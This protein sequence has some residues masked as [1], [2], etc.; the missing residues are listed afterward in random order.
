[1]G[2][3]LVGQGSML[4]T[5]F[6]LVA[7][8]NPLAG[9]LTTAIAINALML[10]LI[11]WGGQVVQRQI[12]S[13]DEAD[14]NVFDFAIARLPIFFVIT[15]VFFF[16][17]EELFGVSEVRSFLIA[18]T[19]GLFFSVFNMAGLLDISD[20]EVRHGLIA[21]MNYLALSIYILIT[22]LWLGN[23]SIEWAGLLNGFCIAII[24]LLTLKWIRK[25]QTYK[26]KQISAKAISTIFREGFL[27]C[28]TLVP[29]QVISRTISVLLLGNTGQNEA[30]LFNFMKSFSGVF[31]QCIT[32]ARRAEYKKVYKA[33]S[34]QKD[35]N[36]KSFKSQHNSLTLGL[37]GIAFAAA[38]LIFIKD[39]LGIPHQLIIALLLHGFLWL[40]SSS[41]FNY[42]QIVSNNWIQTIHVFI[43]YFLVMFLLGALNLENATMGLIFE[44]GASFFA[45]LCIFILEKSKVFAALFS[46]QKQLP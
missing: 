31:T 11:D 33:V 38:I 42:Y 43:T 18:S 39:L 10:I 28:F 5:S 4:L 32:F 7:T 37:V 20:N 40:I 35:L 8:K 41:Y 19:I 25:G 9:A 24:S 46:T 21:G 15:F 16:A 30:A 3:A 1:M 26:K 14:V 2:G 27:V 34:S 45:F 22:T 12:A 36:F 23:L 44:C 13:R 6:V 29:G 17:P